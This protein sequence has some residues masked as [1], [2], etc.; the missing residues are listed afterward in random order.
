MSTKISALDERLQ[1][2][3]NGEEFFPII[4]GTVGAY[5]TYK[6]NLDQLFQSGQGYEKV[7]SLSVTDGATVAS[8]NTSFTLEYTQEDNTVQTLTIEKYKIQDNDV[9]FSHIDPAGYITSTQRISLNNVDNK[10]AT[11]KA[12]DDHIDY[13]EALYDA[14]IKEYIGDDDNGVLADFATLTNVADDFTALLAGVKPELNTF[15]KIEQ[16]FD[17]IDYSD[18]I[19]T[20]QVNIAHFRINEIDLNTRLNIKDSAITANL[21]SVN[22]VTSD[23]IQNGSILRSKIADGAI[24]NDKISDATITAS[25]IKDGT[26][27]P[28]KLSS[29][30]P[31]WDNT[32]VNIPN[33]L[34]VQHVYANGNFNSKGTDFRLYNAS[35]AGT[36]VHSGRALVHS[37]GDRLDI[38]YANDYTGGV[39]IRGVVT[40]P[41]QDAAA[42]NAGG[43]RS[44]V[45]KEYVDAADILINP[46]AGDKIQDNAIAL[47]HMSDNS[48]GTFEILDDS[49]TSEK[50]ENIGPQWNSAGDVVVSGKLTANGQTF[51]LGSNALPSGNVT[52]SLQSSVGGSATIL[53]A[54]GSNGS[55]S[56][57]NT[58][59]SINFSPGSSIKFQVNSN[60]STFSN[61]LHI[62]GA[63]S[64]TINGTNFTNPA[65]LVGSSTNGI[66]IDSNEIIQKGNHLHL[67][68]AD[69][70]T[71]NIYFKEGVNTIATI[72]GNS[73]S[74]SAKGDVISESGIIR[75]N[76][77]TSRLSLRGATA[78][79]NG[80][81]IELYGKS[82][83]NY[84][85]HA[86]YD[87]DQHTFRAMG[88]GAVAFKIDSKTKKVT[89]YGEGTSANH[90]VTKGYVDKNTFPKITTLDNITTRMD[91]GF[92]QTA[93]ASI[94][95]GWPEDRGWYHLLTT[96]H[97]NTNNYHALQFAAS[98]YDQ[99]VYFRST[100][101]KGD[102]EW[103]KLWHTNNDGSGSGLDAD[104]LDGKEATAFSLVGHKHDDLYR[105]LNTK[106]G[107]NDLTTGAPT[108]DS[109]NVVIPNQL[110]VTGHTTI[111]SGGLS[112][113]GQISSTGPDFYLYNAIRADGNT[114]YGRALV[115]SSGDK[116]TINYGKDYT[117]GV[118][119]S[120]TVIAPNQTTTIINSNNK[121]LTTK[122]YVA[123]EIAKVYPDD[124]Y[125]LKTGDIMTGDLRFTQTDLGIN[126]YSDT[127]NA[128]IRFHTNGDEG[129]DNRLE[130]NIGDNANEYFIFTQQPWLGERVEL[131]KIS[132]SEIS[133]KGN[134]IWHDGNTNNAVTSAKIVNY[135]VTSAK[136][137]SNAV[138]TAN[139]ANSSVTLD[140]LANIT[141]GF[142]LGKTNNDTK[143]VPI[144]TNLSIGTS[145][146]VIASGQAAKDYTD[147]KVRGL[148]TTAYVD[149]KIAAAKGT[150]HY[151]DM[152]GLGRTSLNSNPSASQVTWAKGQLGNSVRSGDY[153]MARVRYYESYNWGNGTAYRDR[154]RLYIYGV[155][156][157]YP[158][159][160]WT[161]Y[162]SWYA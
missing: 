121:A 61:P 130:F 157:A 156:G 11:A 132:N 70:A 94:A 126:W 149:A 43:N 37:V 107:V 12:V 1:Q 3:I 151:I 152:Y 24:S 161:I 73:G 131:L 90:L 123:S 64:T 98:Y 93:S 160:V 97:S 89:L 17:T 120:G 139:I 78:Y 81:N 117:G 127:D 115:H 38:N 21:I 105:K 26:V 116:L 51:T 96:T 99:E 108:W 19:G 2:D 57:N 4:D 27:T 85:G 100:G 59:G 146:N 65:L 45:T 22:A 14:S 133:Y 138:T 122:E 39:N 110:N 75:R 124:N 71:Q 41:D 23:K 31:D 113:G 92:Y 145:H 52:L 134:K 129:L 7:T 49:I 32:R 119:I 76:G 16:Q 74:F 42:I 63:G 53:R 47:R 33:N 153:V 111:N 112:V 114:H 128:S 95:E 13:R 87:A 103:N 46:I 20:G 55:L 154:N 148:A 91:S 136:I 140:K 44:V 30:A 155:S 159:S 67:G 56:I 80:A 58:G 147:L 35:R 162:N 10:L 137:A 25:K 109:T 77:E 69:G 144:D 143:L 84:P 88:N 158:N 125:I 101:D 62:T 8:N 142:V 34:N 82:N 9:A 141:S 86:Y 83:I 72:F 36:N 102:R 79:S 48:V 118:E 150:V 40:V 68:V 5:H 54:A 135:A 28:D 18:K 60:K 106:I 6:I 50:I 66:A 15:K 29:G 104:L